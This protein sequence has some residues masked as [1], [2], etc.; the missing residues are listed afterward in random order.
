MHIY[1]CETNVHPITKHARL[2]KVNIKKVITKQRQGPSCLLSISIFTLH[3]YHQ[4][5][6]GPCVE[7]FLFNCVE[8]TP[9]LSKGAP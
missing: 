2:L 3:A 6:L 5:V 1:P 9:S 8:K 4:V 7:N